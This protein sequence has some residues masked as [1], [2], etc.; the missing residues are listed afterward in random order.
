[1]QLTFHPEM[2]R[3]LWPRALSAVLR[4]EPGRG[5][6]GCVDTGGCDWLSRPWR[7]QLDRPQLPW[8]VVSN[9]WSE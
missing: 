8:E 2:L 9:T 6:S 5:V 1:M 3:R 4:G 7:L